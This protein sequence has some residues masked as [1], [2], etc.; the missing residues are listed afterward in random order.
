MNNSILPW[1][2]IT[3]AKPMK[4]K[5]R[6]RNKR[7]SQINKLP[8]HNPNKISPI[9]NTDNNYS[10]IC[11]M[12]LTCHAWNCPHKQPHSFNGC[13]SVPGRCPTCRTVTHDD[14]ILLAKRP[15]G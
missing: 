3:K 9:I 7:N 1:K 5:P 6:K 4:I 8:R 11:P 10:V 14:F 12:Y 2:P 13:L 15:K